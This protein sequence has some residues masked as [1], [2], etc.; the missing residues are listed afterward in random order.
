M[1]KEEAA[2]ELIEYLFK[3][4]K[5]SESMGIAINEFKFKL[6]DGETPK[7]ALALAK[8]QITQ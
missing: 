1:T 3:E 7:M 6:N 5:Y 2:L 8:K 4:C